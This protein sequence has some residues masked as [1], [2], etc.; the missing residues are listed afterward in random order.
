MLVRFFSDRYVKQDLQK[1]FWTSEDQAASFR[2]SAGN[3]RIWITVDIPE[4][5][6]LWP[7]N[8]EGIKAEVG[9]VEVGGKTYEPKEGGLSGISKR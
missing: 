2:I 1:V 4:D 6:D 9:A 3:K 5:K 7:E 8:F